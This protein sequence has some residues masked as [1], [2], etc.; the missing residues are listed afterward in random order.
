MIDFK[1]GE[2]V[3][4]KQ[5]SKADVSDIAPLLISGEDIISC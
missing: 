5:A 2:F 3:K 4:L 1:N